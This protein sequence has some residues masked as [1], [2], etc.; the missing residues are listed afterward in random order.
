MLVSKIVMAPFLPTL[1]FLP[2][3]NIRPLCTTNISNLLLTLL[4]T[5]LFFVYPS[6]LETTSYIEYTIGAPAYHWHKHIPA[7]KSIIQCL[8]ARPGCVRK[9]DRSLDARGTVQAADRNAG[10]RKSAMKR[11]SLPAHPSNG[12]EDD[13]GSGNGAI[14]QIPSSIVGS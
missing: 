1:H 2:H 5:T 13:M 12:R 8:S 4:S 10:T 3:R 14:S 9:L 11:I 7:H 6:L